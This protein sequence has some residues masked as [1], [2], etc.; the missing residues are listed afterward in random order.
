ML[1]DWKSAKLG[2]ATLDLAF[3]LFSSSRLEVLSSQLPAVFQCYAAE[4]AAA[5][6]DLGCD[7]GKIAAP[8]AEEVEAVTEGEVQVGLQTGNST[9]M[10]MSQQTKKKR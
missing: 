5:L 7:D 2:S 3:L 4:Y 6:Q 10:T 8:T 1:L 9:T